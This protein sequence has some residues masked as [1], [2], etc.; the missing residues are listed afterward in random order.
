MSIRPARASRR[1]T[2]SVFHGRCRRNLLVGLALFVLAAAY[3]AFAAAHFASRGTDRYAFDR[4]LV[5]F[6]QGMIHQPLLVRA[7]PPRNN[8]EFYL[9]T[10]ISDKDDVLKGTTVLMLRM[11][12]V[13]TAGGLG[14]VLLTA[15]ATEWEVRSELTADRSS[16]PTD[17]R[18]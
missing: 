8:R 10:V 17:V 6:A 4:P 5:R 1:F 3:A 11:I 14:L 12:I 16:P 9:L 7:V 2:W 13:M 15:G 18:D